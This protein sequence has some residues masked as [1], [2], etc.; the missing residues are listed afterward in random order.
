MAPFRNTSAGGRLAACPCGI[1]FQEGDMRVLAR[2]MMCLS[3][4]VFAVAC[5]QGAG[6]REVSSDRGPDAGPESTAARAAVP[7]EGEAKDAGAKG[8]AAEAEA[9]IERWREVIVPAGTTLSV[10]LD[11][12][13]GSDTSRVEDPVEA[14]VTKAVVID[15]VTAVPEGSRVAGVVTGAERPGKVKGTARLALRFDSLTP[16]ATDERY[17]IHTAT[18]ARSGPTQ[19]KKDALE[20]AA[21]AA[22]GALIGGIVGGK[23]GAVIGGAA[24]GGA[25]TAVVMSQRGQDVRLG[26]G[27]AVTLKLSEPVAVKVKI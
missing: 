14:H 13:V 22:G 5:E 18:I 8:A 21:P 19:K 7:T 6:E 10:A 17:Q 11:T 4:G 9:P 3:A 20:I 23:K 24:G 15:G 27:A 1:K 16:A 2:A 25:G 12:A 26:R